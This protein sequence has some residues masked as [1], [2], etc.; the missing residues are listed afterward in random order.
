M[1]TMR[2]MNVLV[3]GLLLM[4]VMVSACA[5]THGARKCNGHKAV[6]TPMGPM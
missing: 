6:R 4:S 1:K 5:S 2:K 3:I